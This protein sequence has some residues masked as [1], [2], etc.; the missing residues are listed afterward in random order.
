MRKY[1]FWIGFPLTIVGILF[2]AF[3]IVGAY[4]PTDVY[5]GKEAFWTTEE[6]TTFKEFLA[7]DTVKDFDIIVLQSEIPIIVKLNSLIVEEDSYCPYGKEGWRALFDAP[8]ML[9]VGI[10]MVV[11]GTVLMSKEKED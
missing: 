11:G 6:Y 9:Y 1:F 2:L 4:N 3:F 10:P 5:I 7:E 8:W